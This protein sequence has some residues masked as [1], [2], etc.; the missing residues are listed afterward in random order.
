MKRLALVF[1]FILSS[2]LV[3]GQDCDDYFYLCSNIQSSDLVNKGSSYTFT[4]VING[5]TCI[6]GSESGATSWVPS[7]SPNQTWLIVKTSD[8]TPLPNIPINYTS[9][10]GNI[11][12]AYF[13]ALPIQSNFGI[14]DRFENFPNRYKVQTRNSFIELFSS[15][16]GSVYAI[17]VI[18]E[19]NVAQTITLSSS[20]PGVEFYEYVPTIPTCT[21]PTAEIITQSVL[22][23]YGEGDEQPVVVRFTGA[24]PFNYMINNQNYL[25]TSNELEALP[26]GENRLT[27]DTRVFLSDVR[28]SCGTGNIVGDEFTFLYYDKDTT[29]LA[30]FPFDDDYFNYQNGLENISGRGSFVEDRNQVSKSALRLDNQAVKFSGRDMKGEN[31]IISLWI[32]PMTSVNNDQTILSLG[33][34][35]NSGVKL[36][37]V[38]QNTFTFQVKMRNQSMYSVSVPGVIGVWQHIT[39][40][41]DN[42]KIRI[43]NNNN[44]QSE[45]NYTHG[46]VP[47]YGPK[48]VL[49]LGSGFDLSHF[50]NGVVDD[51]KYFS[52]ILPD[53]IITN[54]PVNSSCKLKLCPDVPKITLPGYLHV[55]PQEVKAHYKLDYSYTGTGYLRYQLGNDVIRKENYPYFHVPTYDVIVRNDKSFIPNYLSSSCGTVEFKDSLAVAQSEKLVHCFNFNNNPMDYFN[56]RPFIISEDQYSQDRNLQNNSTIQVG[57]STNISFSTSKLISDNYTV[58]FWFKPNLE[59]NIWQGADIFKYSYLTEDK[60]SFV[61]KGNFLEFSF[62]KASSDPS[63]YVE[64]PYVSNEWIHITLTVGK[65]EIKNQVVLDFYVNGQKTFSRVQRFNPSNFENHG[66][67]QIGPNL[68]GTNFPVNLLDDL[69]IY[70]G[71]LSEPLVNKVYNSSEECLSAICDNYANIEIPNLNQ[72]YFLYGSKIWDSILLKGNG[73]AELDYVINDS[74]SNRVILYKPNFIFDGET[75]FYGNTI[76]NLPPDYGRYVTGE[77]TVK[78]F[79][80]SNH[81]GIRPDTLVYKFYISPKPEICIPMDDLYSKTGLTNWNVSGVQSTLN[82]KLEANKAIKYLSNSSHSFNLNSGIGG[83]FTI[84]LWIKPD[85]QVNETSALL[86]L[87]HVGYNKLTLT[88][89]PNNFVLK[90]SRG[91][92]GNS[93]LSPFEMSTAISKNVWSHIVVSWGKR[94]AKIFIN[95]VIAKE[96]LTQNTYTFLNLGDSPKTRIGSN[97]TGGE[98]YIGSID[99]LRLFNGE[100]NDYEIKAI[101]SN[102]H[103][104]FIPCKKT[105]FVSETINV[106]TSAFGGEVLKSNATLKANTSFTSEKSVVLL[107]GFQT[108]KDIVFKATIDSCPQGSQ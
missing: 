41:K 51:L 12:I 93:S 18:N 79:K 39:L 55:L 64:V 63:F 83:P 45:A 35:N 81:C 105:E 80:I 82:R 54:L 44:Q 103:C 14:C 59:T 56:N 72:K 74:P 24:P 48:S 21:K 73:P 65:T 46:Q 5:N 78:I 30:C 92:S 28:N 29:L 95:G 26:L 87:G 32:K 2:F 52:G 77:N 104:G 6:R 53:S 101:M 66:S 58:S 9:S 11:S 61:R 68:M 49:T 91:I 90:F 16:G 7:Q 102:D 107:P 27:T 84:S 76:F 62:F 106:N 4:G 50:F 25:H 1:S 94:S 47:D 88:Q 31:F 86:T 22:K 20:V 99:D 15:Y 38:N 89:N 100:L 17:C 42:S 3:C 98:Q 23:K 13:G 96:V 69:K 33:S 57:T 97:I 36:S 8:V 75:F 43:L 37:L 60:L 85:E 19:T 40:V 70:A 67:F 108:N 34:T 71:A 10:V